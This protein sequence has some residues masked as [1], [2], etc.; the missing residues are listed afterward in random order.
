MELV[1]VK[2]KKCLW[3]PKNGRENKKLQLK[4]FVIKIPLKLN[5]SV[6][7]KNESRREN[8]EILPE[9]GRKKKNCPWKNQKKTSMAL[10]GHFLISRERKNAV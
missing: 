1:S 10:H 6:R 3:K 9:P 4:I 8:V 7:E 5:E 2:I